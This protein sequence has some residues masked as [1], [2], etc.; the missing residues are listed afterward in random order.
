MSISEHVA[1][2]ESLLSDLNARV[3]EDN[4]PYTQVHITPGEG[5]ARVMSSEFT[6]RHY[7]VHTNVSAVAKGQANALLDR[8]MGLEGQRPVIAGR[9]CD[10]LTVW[11]SSPASDEHALPDRTVWFGSIIWRL[12]SY[13]A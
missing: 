12:T 9:L 5:R 13:A 3:D 7:L 4:Y 1:A 11:A 8:C 6:A 2:I 10:P